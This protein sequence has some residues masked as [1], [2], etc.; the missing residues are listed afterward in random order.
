MLIGTIG[1]FTWMWEILFICLFQTLIRH[2]IYLIILPH[3]GLHLS[4]LVTLSLVLHC[5]L[6]CHLSINICTHVNYL[7]LHLGPASP[8]PPA[9]LVRRGLRFR[10]YWLSMGIGWDGSSE[11]IGLVMGQSII[12]GWMDGW[13]NGWMDGWI[14]G[15]V[16]KILKILL[17]FCFYSY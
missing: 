3:I 7:W 12:Y 17:W 11:F 14:Y 16:K 1:I 8:L 15:C 6:N 4:L 2:A 9:P 13:M 10:E 5:M